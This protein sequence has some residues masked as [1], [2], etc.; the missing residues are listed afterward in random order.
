MKFVSRLWIGLLS[1]TAILGCDAGKSTNGGNIPI[2]I[3][4]TF[5]SM[6][7]ATLEQV[8]TVE[9]PSSAPDEP[10]VISVSSYIENK[11][12]LGQTVTVR[13]CAPQADDLSADGVQFTALDPACEEPVVETLE[14]KSGERT[15]QI[16]GRFQLSAGPGLYNVNVRQLLSS[17]AVT[18]VQVW[19]H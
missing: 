15:P 12:A 2:N 3:P 1:V 10:R 11:G 16:F 7:T 9:Q 19:I 14:L 4:T 6:V 5:R 18:V 17:K 13:A 8:V